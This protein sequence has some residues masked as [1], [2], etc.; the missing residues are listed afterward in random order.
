MAIELYPSIIHEGDLSPDAVGDE[1]NDT[2]EVCPE[3]FNHNKSV[4]IVSFV[5]LTIRA[6]LVHLS[7]VILLPSSENRESIKP[8]KA[9]EPMSFG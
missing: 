4:L 2:V 5:N 8:A 6:N 3:L 7:S 1:I 9:S